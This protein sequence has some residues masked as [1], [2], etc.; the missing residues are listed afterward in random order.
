MRRTLLLPLLMIV[1]LG[2]CASAGAGGSGDGGRDVITRAE[3]EELN[4][5]DA[6]DVV[7]RLRAD[8][9]R[10]R[11]A[12]TFSDLGQEAS[13]PVVYV[14]GNRYGRVAALRSIRAEDVAEIRYLSAADATTQFGTGHTG[15]VLLVTL[16]SGS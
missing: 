8:L 5:R 3:I 1:G 9:L 4:V 2:A 7:E 10:G 6:Y 12:P 11:G 15:G 14:D 16:R 13:R